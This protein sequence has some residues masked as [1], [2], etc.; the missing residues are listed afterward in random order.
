MVSQKTNK[1]NIG[2]LEAGYLCTFPF[3][4]PIR[5]LEKHQKISAV[6]CFFLIYFDNILSAEKHLYDINLLQIEIRIMKPN[7]LLEIKADDYEFKIALRLEFC[8]LVTVE[9][10]DC[11]SKG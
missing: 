8:Q 1:T 10:K 11:F 4:I 6:I 5:I 2:I 9:Q 3:R 7:F